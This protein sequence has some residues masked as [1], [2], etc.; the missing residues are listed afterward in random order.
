MKRLLL[1][2][3]LLDAAW[4]KEL[5]YDDQGRAYDAEWYRFF[6]EMAYESDPWPMNHDYDRSVLYPPG[7]RQDYEPRLYGPTSVFEYCDLLSRKLDSISKRLDTLNHKTTKL[8][9]AVDSLTV[10]VDERIALSRDTLLER[11]PD[12]G[13]MRQYFKLRGWRLP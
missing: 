2:V 10:L 3:L 11:L 4:G 8:Q 7:E 1:L 9:R 13:E 5:A 6:G 12:M